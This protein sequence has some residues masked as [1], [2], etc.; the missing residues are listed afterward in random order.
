MDLNMRLW[1]S[2]DGSNYERKIIKFPN[3]IQKATRIV[4]ISYKLFE[5]AEKLVKL[6]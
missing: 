1:K 2:W 3:T 5:K 4:E 6:R